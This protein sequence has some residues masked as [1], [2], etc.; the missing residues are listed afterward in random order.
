VKKTIQ[1][2]VTKE[3]GVYTAAGVN[4]PIVTE[5]RTPADLQTNIQEA[6]ELYFDGQNAGRTGLYRLSPAERA[7]VRQGIDAAEL[8]HFAPEDEME[9]FYRL[10]R[11]G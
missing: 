11:G 1:F 3:R 10:H 4:V 2:T 6:V 8:G 5:G 7:A 9:E